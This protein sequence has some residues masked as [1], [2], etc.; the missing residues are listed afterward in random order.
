MATLA[1]TEPPASRAPSRSPARSPALSPALRPSR[2]GGERS[3]NAS[4]LGAIQDT[5][6]RSVDLNRVIKL[7]EDS[8][9]KDLEKEQLKSLKKVAKCFENGLPL[10][11]LAQ[12]MEILNLCA[13]KM[14]EQEAF[15]KPLCELIKLCGLPFQKK[16]FSDEISYATVVSKFIAQLGY[17][18]RVPS[19]EV[20]IQICKCVISFYNTEP[21]R[22]LLSGCQPTSTN[23]KIQMAELGGLAETLVLSLAVAESQLIE[24][25]WI[26]KALQHLSSSG[27]NCRLMLKARAAS[28]LCLYLNGDDPSGELVFRSSEILWNLVENTSKEEVCNQLSSLECVHTLKE[29]FEDL[30]MHGFRH[31]DRQLRNDLLV[32][33]TLLAGNPAAPMIESGFAKLLIALATFTEVKFPNPLVKGLKLTR[34]Y[35]DF[36]MKKLLFH[37]IGV[38]SKDPRAVQLLSENDVMPALL[39]YVKPNQKPGFCEWSAAQ[40]E[41]LQLHAIAILASVAPLLI[42]K[43]LSCQA[44]TLLLVFLE[45]CI[46]QD[47]FFGQG[48]SFHGTSGRGNKLAQMRYSLRVLRSVVALYDDAVNLNLCDQG[49]ISQLLD[50]LK[51]AVNKSKEK[52][53]AVLLEIQADVLFILSAV[54]KNDLLRKELFSYEGVDILIPFIQMDPKKL[55]SGLGH[56]FLLLS[57]LDCLWSCVL[58]CYVAEDYFLE[59]QGVFLLLDLLAVK[60]KNLCNIILGILVEFC[61][62]P[63]TTSHISTWR[64]E[65]DQTAASLLIQLWRQEE[66]DL[67]IKRDRYGRIVDM[68]RPITS[69]FQKQQEV[70]PLPAKCPSFAIMEISENIRAKLY[71][72]LCKLGFENL[73]GLSAKDRVTLAIIQHYIDFKVG[74]V[75]SEIRAELKEEFKPIA[76][77]EEALKVLS[78]VSEDTG[79]MVAALQTE[80]LESQHQQE[81]QEEHKTYKKIKAIH[82]QKEML[83]KSW[84]NFLTRTSNYEA[85]KK[86]KTLQEKSIEASR[87]KLKTQNEAV[88]STDIKGLGTTIGSGH[89]VTVKSTPPQLTG[90]PLDVPELALRK[91][92]LSEEALNKD[93][94]LSQPPGA[95]GPGP[96]S[97]CASGCAASAPARPSSPAAGRARAEAVAPAMVRGGAA[98]LRKY[99]SFIDDLRLYVKGGTGGMGYPRLGGQGGR[100]GDVWFIAQ[101]R[102]TLKSIKEKYPLKRFVAGTGANSSVKALKGEKGKDCEVHV[103]LGISVL[104]D[105]GKQIGELNAA[106]E[107]FLAARGGLGG[108]LATNFVPCKGQRRIVRLDLKLIADIGL[109]GF[110]NAGKSSLLS[111]VSHAKPEIANYAFT[112]IQP[113]LGKIMYADYKQISVADLPGL[114]EGAHANKGMGHKFLKHVERTKQLL[115]VVDISGFQLSVKTQFRTAFE[116]ILLLTKE[117]ELYK[118]ELLTKPALLAINKM[119]LPCAK[120]NLNELMKQL[121]NPQ[122][123][124][125]LLEEEMIPANTLEFKDIIPIS[126]YTGEG[127]EE[128]KACIRKSI[129]EEAEQENEEYRKKKLLLLRTSE[130]QMN[131]R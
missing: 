126:T 102:I 118:E 24:K 94:N 31:Y 15:S 19:S 82:K 27:V 93:Q 121:Q 59:K 122:D 131:R 71:S 54:C 18:M 107:R 7:L 6:L 111:K 120:D 88:Y 35:E 100:G 75:W 86:A 50:I 96:L 10:K 73:P 109:V 106:G 99:G 60:Q 26:L 110:P 70:I 95:W 67:G 98:V 12:I 124:L 14:N 130:E 114:I 16:K 22:K 42:D 85:L 33:A 105:D 37:V 83:N 9:S 48:N 1:V 25:L 30:L 63:K 101:E 34:C 23:Y 58:G 11:D 76:S 21:P 81:I 43:Y 125:H 117:L 90:R 32:F 72:L 13:E 129:A 64:G 78:G 17:L 28:R 87:P 53:D 74:E 108:C 119:D 127:I 57:A 39:Y 103:P 89:L 40:Y 4:E 49:A 29:V 97:P 104:C 79:R 47:A 112:T 5:Q 115:L 84:E 41:E 45:W 51:Y 2:G 92:P 91:L 56:N 62:N 44:N 66:L 3:R 8:N 80:V 65:K 38:F 20:R 116:T 69:S 52:E 46:G 77:D 123:Y 55:Y 61:D 128:L 113:Q 36:E 68:K